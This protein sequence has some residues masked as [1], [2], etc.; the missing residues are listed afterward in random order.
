MR[1]AMWPGS[2]GRMCQASLVRGTAGKHR[3]QSPVQIGV[4]PLLHRVVLLALVATA[5][6]CGGHSNATRLK[7]EVQDAIGTEAY[8]LSCDPAGGTVP[9]PPLTCSEF[10]RHPNLLV[11]TAADGHSC[12]PGAGGS[13]PVF[14][15]AGRYRG[16]NVDAWFLWSACGGIGDARAWADW[17]GLMAGRDRGLAEPP[18]HP[19]AT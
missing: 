19:P 17:V 6:A 3:D 2:A 9:N 13:G 15:V 4:K 10:R 11:R 5:S 1:R 18:L 16:R 8:M 14:H 7:I 12:P